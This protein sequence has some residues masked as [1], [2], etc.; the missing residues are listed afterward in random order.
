MKFLNLLIPAFISGACVMIVELTGS[1]IIAP[2]L[3]TTIYTW[4]AVIGLVMAALSLGYFYGGNLADKYN[5]RKHLANIFFLAAF[6]TLI[7]P[8]LANII[9]PFTVLIPLSVASIVSAL[10]LVPASFFYGMVSPYV[11]KLISRDEK[12][13]KS[14][15]EV[16]AISTIGSIVGTLGSGFLLIPNFSITWIFIGASIAMLL[17]GLFISKSINKVDL[18]MFGLFLIPS[19]WVGFTPLVDGD[20]LFQTNTQYY[21]VNVFDN[22]E[23]GN[24]SGR[25]LMLDNVYSSM[26]K[27]DGSPVFSYIFDARAA[28]NL[29]N[30]PKRALVIGVAAGTQVED[31]KRTYPNL[32]VDGVEIDPKVIEVGKEYF[33]LEDDNRTNIIIDDGRRFVKT[34]N[35]TYD[36]IL[37]DVFRG[38]SIPSHLTSIEFVKELKNTTNP[39]SVIIANIISSV[40]G[41]KS[42]FLQLIYNTYSEE[43]DNVLILPVGDDPNNVQNVILVA[44]DTDTTEFI[45]NQKTKIYPFKPETNQIV[46]DDLNPTEVLVQ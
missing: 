40:E 46:T 15:G 20:L 26:E 27:P 29:S 16:F 24:E 2:Y 13:G 9:V 3:G 32:I 30:D 8:I 4:A 38:K 18:F 42:L 31:L 1:K 23:Y 39:D 14:S 7:I 35:E 33:N 25:L 12:V 34:T 43:F 21:M 5:D 22:V 19:F 37:L 10:I 41:E 11:I 45:I 44:T 6:C 17:S 36:I 28:Y